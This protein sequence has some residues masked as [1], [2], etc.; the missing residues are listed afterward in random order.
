MSRIGG[1]RALPAGLRSGLGLLEQLAPTTGP[2]PIELLEAE[3][4]NRQRTRL[5]RSETVEDDR[6]VPLAENLVDASEGG[7]MRDPG[8]Q[9][10]H[11]RRPDVRAHGPFVL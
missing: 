11:V 2:E 9:H 7:S 1:E 10:G 8:E 5:E 3:R 6:E 4:V